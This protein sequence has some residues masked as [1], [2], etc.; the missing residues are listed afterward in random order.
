MKII[1]PE[2]HSQSDLNYF[3]AEKDFLSR[4]FG[5]RDHTL[6]WDALQPPEPSGDAPFGRKDVEPVSYFSLHDA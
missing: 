1:I 6:T 2:T 4:D 3:S 5:V